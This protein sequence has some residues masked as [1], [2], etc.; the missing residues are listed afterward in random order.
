MLSAQDPEISR[1]GG[2]VGTQADNISSHPERVLTM[3]SQMT[4]GTS[5]LGKGSGSGRANELMLEKADLSWRAN[6]I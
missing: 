4:E 1:N 2:E 5:H 6:S 3:M